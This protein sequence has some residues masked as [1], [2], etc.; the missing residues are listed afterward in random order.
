[1]QCFRCAN[2]ASL[3]C[4]RRCGYA[5]C[6]ECSSSETHRC[7]VAGR[8]EYAPHDATYNKQL[9][10][11]FYDEN[12]GAKLRPTQDYSINI[13]QLNGWVSAV[14]SSDSPK[15][16]AELANTFAMN[17]THV[18]FNYFHMKLNQV[19]QDVRVKIEAIKPFKTYAIINMNY[20]KSTTWVALLVW[21]VLRSVVTDI[22]SDPR[23]IPV[24]EFEQPLAIIH[25]DDMSYSGT[26]M[27]ETVDLGVGLFDSVKTHYYVLVPFLG[28]RAKQHLTSVWKHLKFSSYTTEM[29]TLGD[30]FK[31]SGYDG[32]E[33][34]KKLGQPTWYRL[35]P[36]RLPHNLVYFDHKLAD[37]LSVPTKMFAALYVA[38]A[39]GKVLQTFHPIRGCEDNV[40][41]NDTGKL[42]T[43]D[44]SVNDW[45]Q[46]SACPVSF[47]K[48]I[49][50]TFNDISL[51]SSIEPLLDILNKM[52]PM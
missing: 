40:Y 46:A 41:K 8:G 11:Q 33:I 6:T 27:G 50:Y 43:P 1:M 32:Y 14:N 25:M 51:E 18:G 47:Y 13:E 34:V 30:F 16:V 23:H 2:S 48:G 15:E 22:V 12:R 36:V 7:R 38:D 17:L 42:L 29:A 26:Q 44:T 24:E 49:N 5:L 31:W 19:A 35:Y 37:A 28:K 21:D 3:R 10:D 4:K 45:E 20:R 39:D 52:Q 9:F